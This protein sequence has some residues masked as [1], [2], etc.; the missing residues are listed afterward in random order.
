MSTRRKSNLVVGGL[1]ALFA[2]GMSA[3]PLVLTSSLQ[4]KGKNLITEIAPLAPLAVGRGAYTNSGSK[5]VGADPD[6][7]LK[8]RSWRGRPVLTKRD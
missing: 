6:W 3:V 8:T 2:V 7:D 1:V 5:D 4:H